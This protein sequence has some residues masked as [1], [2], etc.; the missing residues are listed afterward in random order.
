MQQSDYN[1]GK[2]VVKLTMD[3]SAYGK[4]HKVA[5]YEYPENISQKRLSRLEKGLRTTLFRPRFANGEPHPTETFKM[6]LSLKPLSE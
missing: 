5:A 4:A 3:I 1:S 2:Q 6:Q